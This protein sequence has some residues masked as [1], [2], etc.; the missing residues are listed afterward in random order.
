MKSRQNKTK[1]H[2]KSSH[3]FRFSQNSR[4]SRQTTQNHTYSHKI[5]Q[6]RTKS[7]EIATNLHETTKKLHGP[8]ESKQNHT[9]SHEITTKHKYI[10][11]HKKLEFPRNRN[12]LLKKTHKII[13]SPNL[14]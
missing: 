13:K 8:E 9:Q 1:I 7:L 14:K 6:N 3:P 10:L 4:T 2:A 5:P 12:K 11:N